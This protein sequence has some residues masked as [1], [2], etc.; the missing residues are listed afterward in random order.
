MSDENYK[1]EDKQ[2]TANDAIK[3]LES[4]VPMQQGVPFNFPFFPA[5]PILPGFSHNVPPGP[6]NQLPMLYM[7]PSLGHYYQVPA[8]NNSYLQTHQIASGV[9]MPG[10]TM[11]GVAAYDP[12]M[13]HMYIPASHYPS[14]AMLI[15]QT[16]TAS[17]VGF[18]NTSITIKG[19]PKAELIE[20]GGAYSM[21]HS[22][23]EYRNKKRRAEEP[24]LPAEGDPE[25]V[26]DSH[27]DDY[28]D[29]DDDSVGSSPVRVHKKS[30]AKKRKLHACEHEGCRYKTMRISNLKKHALIHTGEKPFACTVDGCEYKSTQL[31]NLNAHLKRHKLRGGGLVVGRLRRGLAQQLQDAENS[32][33]AADDHV[34]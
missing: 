3:R 16:N 33:N 25:T 15:P 18:E 4:Y 29:D 30:M 17:S 6:M 10:S 9:N 22:I 1:E 8:S 13:S 19:N 21:P 5:H 14:Q 26:H 11:D 2:Q 27:E 28:Y 20:G 7:P 32:K 23:S 12:R 34:I 24:D 31:C